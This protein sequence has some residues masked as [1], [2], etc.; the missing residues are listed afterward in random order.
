MADYADVSEIEEIQK[1]YANYPSAK[2]IIRMCRTLGVEED[3][4]RN[5]RE[6]D[7]WEYF[8]ELLSMIADAMPREQLYDSLSPY[9][10]PGKIE[11]HLNY[12]NQQQ[13]KTA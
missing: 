11:E 5:V 9:L 13:R 3:V 2:A 8:Y 7:A 12:I 6:D 10:S 1:L 4:L